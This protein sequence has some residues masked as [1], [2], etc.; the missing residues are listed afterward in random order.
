[1]KLHTIVFDASTII[2]LA[3]VDLLQMIAGNI[4]IVIPEAVQKEVLVKPT[5]YDAQVIAQMLKD[6]KMSVFSRVSSVHVKKLQEHLRLDI[7]EA[8]ALS[9]A[10]ENHWIL[11]IDDGPGIR[12]AKILDVPFVTAIH[13][14]IELYEQGFINE[15][16]ALTK[17]E[18]L[19]ILGRYHIQIIE[20]AKVRIKK[21]R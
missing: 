16:S 8:E 21:K 15:H 18:S 20:D 11:G 9:L 7:G 1:M 6:K 19:Q 13:I 5:Y 14:L 17:L 4:K 2:L 12:A 3:K 10:K